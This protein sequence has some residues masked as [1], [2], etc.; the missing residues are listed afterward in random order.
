MDTVTAASTAHATRL[1]VRTTSATEFVDVTAQVEALVSTCGLR[2]GM[3]S[4]QTTHTT[5][6]VVVNEHEPLLLAD[7]TTLLEQVAPR[8]SDYAHDD[9]GRRCGVPPDEP[10]NGHAHCRAL[11][12]PSSTVVNVSEGRLT[13]GRWQRVFLVELDGP[14]QRE[15]S[16]VIYGEARL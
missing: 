11:I 10:A 12:L 2:T 5:T 9:M 6:A 16:I 4:I 8:G 15:L 3:V 1:A 14:R 7:F 13:L